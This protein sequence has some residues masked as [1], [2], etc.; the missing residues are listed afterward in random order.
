VSLVSCTSG[1]HIL[2]SL[3]CFS[4]RLSSLLVM[5]HRMSCMSRGPPTG[6]SPTS[7]P[8]IVVDVEAREHPRTTIS[9]RPANARFSWPLCRG[10]SLAPLPPSSPPP[11]L[12]LLY[13]LCLWLRL[14]RLAFHAARGR[15]A[16]D[17]QSTLRRR[18]TGGSDPHRRV[19]AAPTRPRARPATTAAPRPPPPPSTPPPPPPPPPPRPLTPLAGP[20][21]ARGA[22]AAAARQEEGAGP[23]HYQRHRHLGRPHPVPGQG[24][25]ASYAPSRPHQRHHH[26]P[27]RNNSEPPPPGA[28]L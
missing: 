5:L 1:W 24:R 17:S 21:H 6:D 3:R 20:A 25:F 16:T 28:R 4:P 23:P 2:A 22:A 27:R 9:S 13:A 14:R 12:L 8:P 15:K 10:P 7:R 18:R 26:E 19:R 11:L